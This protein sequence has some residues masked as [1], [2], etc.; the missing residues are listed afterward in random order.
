M[1]FR[2]DVLPHLDAAYN[3]ARWLAG[4]DADADDVLQDAMLR[5][6]R[7]P[8]DGGDAP[9]AWFLRIVRNAAFALLR[10]RRGFEEVSDDEPSLEPDA[11]MRLVAAADAA[12]LRDGIDALAPHFR[13]MVVLRELEELSYEEIA[14]VAQVPIGTVMSRLHRARALLKKNLLRQERSEHA[15]R[16]R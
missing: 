13:E 2:R 5:A 1:S 7:F 3:L 16:S 4:N 8:R 6:H 11:A 9:R 10:T 15:R 14:Q 12:Q